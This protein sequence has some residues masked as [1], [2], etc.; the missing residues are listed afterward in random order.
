MDLAGFAVSETP[1]S[2]GKADLGN[3][4]AVPG[5][6]IAAHAGGLTAYGLRE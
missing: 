1:V 6:L 4:A 5:R 2:D 3:L